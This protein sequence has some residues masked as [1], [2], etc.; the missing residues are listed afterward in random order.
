MTEEQRQEL[1][2]WLRLEDQDPSFKKVDPV[3][4]NHA[5]LTFMA[6]VA[7]VKNLNLA[8]VER[9]TQVTRQHQ[10]KL[11]PHVNVLDDVHVALVN[12]LKWGMGLHLNPAHVLD[13]VLK[14]LTAFGFMLLPVGG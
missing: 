9:T 10:R 3:K 14:Q 11:R 4:V 1:D 2:L 6:Q 13:R 12:L 8:D 5:V 7:M